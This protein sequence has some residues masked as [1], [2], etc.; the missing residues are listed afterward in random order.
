MK[1]EVKLIV[2]TSLVINIVLA[3]VKLFGGYLGNTT[4][5]V[6]DG[7]NSL[8]DIIISLM[9][10]ITLSLSS[11]KPDKDHPYGH[12]KYEGIIS[13]V[14]GLFLLATAGF[15]LY[16]GVHNLIIYEKDAIYIRPATFTL[17][18][19]L[20]SIILKSV[21]YMINIRGYKK[22][23]QVSLKAESYNHLSD[24]FATVASLVGII[25]ATN[26]VIY[27]DYVASIIIGLVIFKTAYSVIKEA[28]SFLVDEAPSKEDMAA[29]RKTILSVKGILS[30]D[31]LKARKHV[32]KV[33]V[34]VEISVD[35]NLSLIKAHEIAEDVHLTI[36][37]TF[38]EVI[39]C[40]VHFNPK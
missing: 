15:I 24:I 29:I 7:Y 23:Q 1:R 17:Y 28:V 31:V 12:E 20:G 2:I 32:S 21:V 35:K 11:K 13:F 10:I 34:D 40:M 4:S 22:Y 39:H 16:E 6:S 8:T 37:D 30:I 38:P 18:I 26:G 3:I 27:V 14:L 19:A 33:Y 5:L 25:F 36:E 9:L